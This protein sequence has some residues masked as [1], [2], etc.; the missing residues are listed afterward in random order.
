MGRGLLPLHP[1]PAAA[2]KKLIFFKDGFFK[3]V[4]YSISHL[5]TFPG[6]I[7]ESL[8]DHFMIKETCQKPQKNNMR[9]PP[10]TVL[11]ASQPPRWEG[12]SCIYVFCGFY[13]CA[14]NC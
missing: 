10:Q 8:F 11:F 14:K 1:H 3:D 4:K 6:F 13:G 2:W 9:I 7:N 12:V 5:Y